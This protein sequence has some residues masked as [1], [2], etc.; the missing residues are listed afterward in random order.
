MMS[1]NDSFRVNV[2]MIC[3]SGGYEIIQESGTVLFWYGC[4]AFVVI[5]KCETVAKKHWISEP[6]PAFFRF[7]W[8]P[9]IRACIIQGW[10]FRK[11]AR[12]WQDG[13]CHNGLEEKI[14]IVDRRYQRG[15]SPVFGAASFEVITIQ[16]SV[17][18]RRPRSEK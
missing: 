14:E 18:D 10:R 3:R 8:K 9:R 13:A 17:Y 5:C 16:S 12:I 6:E 11:R 1:R 7:F 2:W 4:G 15:S